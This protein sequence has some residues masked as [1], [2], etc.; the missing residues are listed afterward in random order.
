M[1]Q[2]QDPH[3]VSDAQVPMSVLGSTP[4]TPG[5]SPTLVRGT[6]S[7]TR[8]LAKDFHWTVWWTMAVDLYP[9]ANSPQS[10]RIGGQE[11]L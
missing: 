9:K 8:D 2:G 7:R 6:G 11:P 4:Y 1:R 10:L 3:H 5:D